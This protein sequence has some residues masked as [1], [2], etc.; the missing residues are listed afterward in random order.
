MAIQIEVSYGMQE[1]LLKLWLQVRTWPY[2]ERCAEEPC[3]GWRGA[4]LRVGGGR[5]WAAS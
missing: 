5:L 4:G 3:R 2:V 1:L